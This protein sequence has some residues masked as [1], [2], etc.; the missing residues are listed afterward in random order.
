MRQLSI[1]L[2]TFL[3]IFRV[4]AQNDYGCNKL[5]SK[6]EKSKCFEV[7]GLDK[8]KLKNYG[9]AYTAF[10]KGI[11]IIGSD[12]NNNLRYIDDSGQKLALAKIENQEGN[13]S[14]A[15]NLAKNVLGA[16]IVMLSNSNE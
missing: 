5:D 12:Y 2:F 4:V 9:E 15:S 11:E 13:N 7:V 8:L 1:F 16:R 3:I 10:I 14:I 6:L